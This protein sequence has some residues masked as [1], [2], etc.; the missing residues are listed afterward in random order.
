MGTAPAP[1]SAL[2]HLVRVLFQLFLFAIEMSISSPRTVCRPKSI[3]RIV[4]IDF[5]SFDFCSF[6]L[7]FNYSTFG[8][9][10]FRKVKTIR[11]LILVV[12]SKVP[13]PQYDKRSILNN[14]TV[15]GFGHGGRATYAI[16]L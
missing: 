11:L 5:Y 15:R 14:L 9:P 6:V 10:N 12:L 16:Y 8:H 7:R 2:N 13:I 4:F 3:K 1:L